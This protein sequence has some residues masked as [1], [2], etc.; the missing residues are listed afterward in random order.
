MEVWNFSWLM[1]RLSW[2][3]LFDILLVAG[4]FFWLFYALKGTRAAPLVRGIT[5]LL[6]T[7]ALLSRIVRLRAFS[8]VVTQLF[9]T[10]LIAIPV[11]FQP[12]LRRA[13]SR[14]GRGRVF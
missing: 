10:L 7:L 11:I 5:A 13:L 4:L 9:P 1:Q 2:P 3:D 8:W 6:V 14:L 12:E